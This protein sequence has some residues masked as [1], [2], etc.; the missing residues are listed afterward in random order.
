[1]KEKLQWIKLN[2]RGGDLKRC[3]SA[4]KYNL[5]YLYQVTVGDRNNEEMLDSVILFIR[6]VA[7]IDKREV[8]EVEG[9]TVGLPEV[10]PTNA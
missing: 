8:I 1:M 3:A 5:E 10:Q 9:M 2:K 4:N 6:S 7:A